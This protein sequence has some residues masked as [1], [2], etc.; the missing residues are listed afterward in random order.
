[1]KQ[2][3]AAEQA[4]DGSDA[5]FGEDTDRDSAKMAWA[6]WLGYYNGLLRKLGWNKEKLVQVSAEY[7][8]TM[9][10]TQIPAIPAKTIGK[11]GLKVWLRATRCKKLYNQRSSPPHTCNA[12]VCML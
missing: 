9:G 11:M 4:R 2:L 5:T 1:M 12:V 3:A 7:A 8:S 6:A 10:F